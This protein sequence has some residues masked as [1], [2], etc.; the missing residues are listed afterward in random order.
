MDQQTESGRLSKPSSTEPRISAVVPSYNHARFV[1]LTLRSI[2]KQTLAPAEL[3]VIDDGST[4]ESP[5]IIERV[6]HESPIPCELIARHNSGLCATLNEGLGRTSGEYFAYLGS[7]DLWMPEFLAARAATL[8]ERPRAVLGYGHAL[9]ID[10]ANQVLDCTRDWA[11]YSDGNAR[12]MLLEQTFAPMS[13]TV[14][15]RRSALARHAWFEQARLEDYDLYLRLSADGD[16]AFDP[17]ILSAWRQHE[18]N[19]SRD[20]LWMIDARLDAQRRVADQIDLSASQLEHFQRVLRFAGAEDLLRLSDKASAVKL[21]SGNW[22]GAPS[23]AAK[24]R[25]L[26]RLIAPQSVNNLRRRRKHDQAARRYG[27]VQI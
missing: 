16:F 22:S 11:N 6:L 19:A 24:L 18:S 17:R 26:L 2:F 5:R 9:L 13:P 27:S 25:V 4:D 15:Y 14:V 8:A 21:L 3:L 12:A 20:F 23:F 10:A 1:E 7:D